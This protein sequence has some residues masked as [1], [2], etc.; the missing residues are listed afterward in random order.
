[1]LLVSTAVTSR[2]LACS[3]NDPFG[4]DWVVA[5]GPAVGPQNLYDW[6]VVSDG[7][8]VS[9][10]V[11]ARNVTKFEQVY[12]EQVYETLSGLGY[13]KTWNTPLPTRQAGCVY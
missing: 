3:H 12:Q 6:A 5:L 9:L 1:V 10:F 2:R 13:N 11:L 7:L 4:A 8:E